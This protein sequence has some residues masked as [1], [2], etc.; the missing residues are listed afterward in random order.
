MP[1]IEVNESLFFNLLGRA[2]GPEE[3]ERILPSAKAELDGWDLASG[4]GAAGGAG[5]GAAKPGDAG[6]VDRSIKIELNDTNRP[7]LW[8]T[9]GLARQLRLAEGGKR[10]EYPFFSWEGAPRPASK[11]V[12]VEES[13]KGVRPYLA[14][15]V[16]KGKAI[17][18]A[19]LK[20]LIQTQEKLAWNFGRKR[21]T[22]SMGLYRSGSIQWPV[23][24]KAVDPKTTRFVPLQETRSMSLREILAE[25]PKGKEYA[26]ILEKEPLHPLLVDAKGG[27]LSYP[28]IINSA[29]L[30]AVQVGDTE[31]FVE[32][33]GTDLP[34]VVLSA[35]IAACD[36]SDMG[37]SVEPVEVDYAY[38]TAFGRKLVTPFYFQKPVSVEAARVARLLGKPFSVQAVADAA[39]RMGS[40]VDIHGQYVAVRPAEYRNDFLHAVDVVEDVMIGLGMDAF[41]PERPRDF[42]IGR[43]SPI[44][45]FSRKAKNAM[46]GLGYQEMI[47]NYLGSRRDYIDKMGLDPESLVRISN[48]M[49]ENFEYVRNSPLP[50]LFNSESVSSQAAYPHRLFEVGKVAVKDKA[51]NY[52]VATRQYIGVLSCHAAADFNEIAAQVATLLYYL[53]RDFTV[54]DP[55]HAGG[56]DPRFIPGRQ[57]AVLYKGKRA[58]IYGETNPGLLEAWGIAMP[59]A[60]AELD[61]DA[62]LA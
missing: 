23:T 19:V 58:G 9:A 62:F 20:D 34:S 24:Y 27:V 32:L 12:V 44:E 61:L 51:E 15:F 54:A 26:F 47:Y 52:G 17:T 49:S 30:G 42:T 48:P 8:S 56:E 59:C 4:A 3:L 45:A 33:T 1:K 11:K 5:G 36:L 35:S 31:L 13:V 57:A 46:T 14:G 40:G 39:V 38:D 41:A 28:P 10:P 21:R 22:V 53:G 55:A 2:C 37:Y 50:S 29:D 25:H 18:D 7:D 6:A 60:A 43:L 16:V